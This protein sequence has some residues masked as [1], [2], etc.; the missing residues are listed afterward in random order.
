M[1]LFMLNVLCL[2][3]KKSFLFDL[4]SKICFVRFIEVKF[5]RRTQLSVRFTQVSA[6]ECPLYKGDFMRIWS[7]NG[8]DQIFCPL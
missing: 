5:D 3:N 6:L 4:V 8:R 2:V 7:E 1:P